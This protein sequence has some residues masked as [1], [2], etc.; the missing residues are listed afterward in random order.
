MATDKSE[1]R[2]GIIVQVGVIAI[3]TL[4]VVRAVLVAYFDRMDREETLRKVGSPDAL[5]SVRADEA[6]RLK[7]GAMPIDQA[8]QTMAAKGRMG[9]SPDIMPSASKDIA[10]LQG[11]L[12]MPS[13]VPPAMTASAS[14]PPPAPAAS[15]AAPSGS[16]PPHASAAPPS[17]AAP[18]GSQRPRQ[19]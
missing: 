8:M 12:K 18:P 19:P 13:E 2:T 5:I 1:P 7:T 9:A 14:P 10:P 17:S 6:Q 11:W 15:S 4:L 3:V 16:A